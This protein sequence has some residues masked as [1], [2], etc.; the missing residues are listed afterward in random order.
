MKLRLSIDGRLKLPDRYS[1]TIQYPELVHYHTNVVE[2]SGELITRVR[3]TSRYIHRLG[4]AERNNFM[5]KSWRQCFGASAA[6]TLMTAGLSV[7]AGVGTAEAATYTCPA[8]N[9]L[10]LGEGALL[11]P[12]WV[13]ESNCIG[14]AGNDP[15]SITDTQTGRIYECQSIQATIFPDPNDTFVSG[16][17]C[18]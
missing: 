12:Y 14:P 3:T 8:I 13:I 1:Q 17:G 15:G 2:L 7:L 18:R 5:S 10:F 9:A 16:I 11:G 4:Y 6:V